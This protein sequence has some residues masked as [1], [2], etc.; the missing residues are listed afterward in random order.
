MSFA[1]SAI[2]EIVV[3]GA[4]IVIPLAYH[5]RL[6][7]FHWRPVGV[8][9]PL[10]PV[11]PV[12]PR[13]VVAHTLRTASGPSLPRTFVEPVS[14][15]SGGSSGALPALVMWDATPGAG[16]GLGDFVS[17]PAG[18]IDIAPRPVATPPPPVTRDPPGAVRP[19]GPVRVGGDV[20]NAKLIRKIVPDY[21]ALAISA[22]IS[23]VVR[24][25]GTIA[26]DGTIQNLQ[27]VSGHPLL[28][29]AAVEAVSQWVYRPTLLN[30][31]PVEVIAPIEVNFT[32]GQ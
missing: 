17:G 3:V 23:G 25:T 12:E 8:G 22:R 31:Q 24:L 7:S 30:G 14:Q 6:P 9:A 4:L 18:I 32:L 19:S 5:D 15:P 10:K 27:V 11:E 2:A 16:F 29:R 13:P 20:Q 21:P 26:R 28:V 1:A